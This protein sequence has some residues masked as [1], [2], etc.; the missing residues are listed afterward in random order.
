MEKDG[1]KKEALHPLSSKKHG[2]FHMARV[3]LYMIR[4]RSN[5]KSVPAH[6]NVVEKSFWK[7]LV[8]AMRPL[9]HHSLQNSPPLPLITMGPATNSFHDV[10]QLP[11]PSPDFMPRVIEDGMSSR[12]TSAVDLKELDNDEN[13][14]SNVGHVIVIANDDE[15]NGEDGDEPSGPNAIDMQAEEFIANFYE[16]MR[17]QRMESMDRYNRMF[18]GGED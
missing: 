3:A 7:R 10:P 6:V 15:I 13:G 9:H 4:R 16:Q 1:K 11:P 12:Y 18:N 14:G 5:H 2:P 8:C 17:L